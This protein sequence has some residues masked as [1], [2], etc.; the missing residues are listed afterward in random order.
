MKKAFVVR[1]QV[2]GIIADVVYLTEP[3]EEQLAVVL[4]SLPL[5]RQKDGSEAPGW[6]KAHAVCID[7]DDLGVCEDFEEPAAVAPSGRRDV[8]EVSIEAVGTVESVL[9]KR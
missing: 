3:T 5:A 4:R 6:I 9:G 8:M 7:G 2:L 1:H